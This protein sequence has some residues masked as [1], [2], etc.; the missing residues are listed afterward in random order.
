MGHQE[1]TDF[2]MQYKDKV[3][4]TVV[5]HKGSVTF[6]KT[7]P[8]IS[9]NTLSLI[10]EEIKDDFGALMSNQYGNYFCQKLLH[11]ASSEQR[12]KLLRSLSRCF[13][14]VSCDEV[15]THSMQRLV[16]MLN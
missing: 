5:T 7:L 14:K 10:I 9:I 4:E 2:Y 3:A 1:E 11:H 12:L 6:Q 15:G 13:I 8:K 16:E